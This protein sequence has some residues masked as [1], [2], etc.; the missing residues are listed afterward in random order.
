MQQRPA[1]HEGSAPAVFLLAWYRSF[2][3]RCCQNIMSSQETIVRSFRPVL[4]A[5]LVLGLLL[6][7]APWAGA[8]TY[9]S[10][11][12]FPTGRLRFAQPTLRWKVWTDDDYR[13]EAVRMTLNGRPVQAHYSAADRAAVYSPEAPLRAGEYDVHCV[14]ILNG[15]EPL[16]R[17]WTFVVSQSAV[18]RLPDPDDEPQRALSVANRYRRIMGLPPL[19]LDTALCASADSHSRYLDTNN[20]FGH[21]ELPGHNDFVGRDLLERSAAFGYSGG[22]YEDVSYGSSNAA[23][24]V[25]RLFEA[26]YHRLP[27]MQPGSPDFGMGRAG[28]QTTLEF[29]LTGEEGVAVYPAAGQAGVP[30]SWS[31]SE[32]PDPLGPHGARG[33]TGFVVTYAYFAP[34]SADIDVESATLTDASG[35]AVRCYVNTPANDSH[36]P[37]GVFLIPQA[38]LRPGATYT[39]DVRAATASGRDI[40]RRWSFTTERAVQR[41][42]M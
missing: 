12:P 38:P 10:L 1:F 42:R 29:G 18:A 22:G 32:E 6:A 14:V 30:R 41:S 15:G 2:R 37:N 16:Q 40:S 24:A 34:D 8:L 27:F 11:P 35:N 25:A 9:Y 31:G 23:V 36:L 13:V 20:E 17:D 39:A 5:A 28:K 33:R 4:G 26:P 3:A 7:L 19:R 21:T